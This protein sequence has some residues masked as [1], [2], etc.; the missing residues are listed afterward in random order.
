MRVLVT[1]GAGYIGSHTVVE[2]LALDHDVLIVDNL[3]N[4]SIES[5]KRIQAI[6]K[7]Y[8]KFE[9]IDI[10]DTDN[11]INAFKKFNPEC[12]I[13]F[14]GL[15]AVAE[16]VKKPLSYYDNNVF[17]SIS[18]LKAMDSVG[19][20]NIIFSS[21]ATVYGDP[22]YLPIDENH[23][24]CPVN[25]YGNTKLQIEN[26]IS[27]W[28]GVDN[29]KTATILRYFNPVGAHPS[30]FIGE[31]PTG[32]PNNLMPYIAEVSVGKRE[33]LNIFGNDYN[34]RDGSGERDFIHVVDLAQAH[35]ASINHSKHSSCNIFNIGTGHG[36]TVLELVKAF[37]EASNKS[38]KFQIVNRREGDVSSSVASVKKAN[39]C[40]KWYAKYDIYEMCSDVW[41][42]QSNN[43]EGYDSNFTLDQE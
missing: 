31:N 28:I 43:P 42:W 17:G 40:L 32:V 34:T 9:K 33:Y 16:S 41:N 4:S 13:H 8:C 19:C 5:I 3:V 20:R 25:P 1:G 12:V 21:S 23:P 10:R 7:K 36:T 22:Q 15:K 38:I 27:D 37:E 2:L 29:N 30:G 24:C 39:N 35:V 6:S 26:L 11:M 14:A 18:L